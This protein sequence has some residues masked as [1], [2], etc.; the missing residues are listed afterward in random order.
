MGRPT[1]WATMVSHQI[2]AA[3]FVTIAL[4]RPGYS[5][6]TARISSISF[7]GT[8]DAGQ[9]VTIFVQRNRRRGFNE[10]RG[11]HW[12][13]ASRDVEGLATTVTLRVKWS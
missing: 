8:I 4:G 3:A 12:W 13:N 5:Q 2:L 6:D 11:R 9:S 10:R 7:A 1:S